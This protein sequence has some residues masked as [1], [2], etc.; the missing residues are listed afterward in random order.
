MVLTDA[1]RKV[2]V[3][4]RAEVGLAVDTDFAIRLG[5]T[6][7][8]AAHVSLNRM[9]FQTRQTSSSL[10]RTEL[11]VCWKIYDMVAA[12]EDLSPAEA[13][14]RDALLRKIAPLTLREHCLAFRRKE[15]VRVLLSRTF[16][17]D[18]GALTSAYW[19]AIILLPRLAYTLRNM[20]TRHLAR[21]TT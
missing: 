20:A 18:R 16:P 3:R 13:R 7:R 6:Y 12:L 9:T 15:A 11:D 2:G 10:S 5:Q 14:A 1:A 4:D 21:S 17:H 19:V 8:G